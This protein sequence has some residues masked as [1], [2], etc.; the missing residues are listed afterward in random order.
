MNRAT[1]SWTTWTWTWTWMMALLVGFAVSGGQAAGAQSAQPSDAQSLLMSFWQKVGDAQAID[2]ALEMLTDDAV[3]R[4]TP[5]PPG[6]PGVWTGKTELRQAL[7]YASENAVGGVLQGSA[8]VSG[9][10]ATASVMMSNRF[11][12][13]WGVAPVKFSTE[14]VVENGK[15]KSFSNTIAPE[16]RE[17]VAAAAQAAQ[18]GQAPAGMPRTGGDQAG[19]P[20]ALAIAGLACLLAAMAARRRYSRA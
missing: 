5:A 20:V 17:R 2:S 16:E 13:A 8:Q 12:V 19:A 3:L 7:Q 6:T 14:L 9:N 15:I 18:A 4:I 11:L 10:T 1:K